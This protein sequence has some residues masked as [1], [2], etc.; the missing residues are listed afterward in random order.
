M[1]VQRHPACLRLS[2]ALLAAAGLLAAS[3]G[4]KSKAPAYLRIRDLRYSRQLSIEMIEPK[5]AVVTAE[6]VVEIRG[7]IRDSEAAVT[8]IVN[9]RDAEVDGPAKSTGEFSIHALTLQ[10]GPNEIVFTARKGTLSNEAR[11]LIT[12]AGAEKIAVH[13]PREKALVADR[14][15]RVE[16]EAPASFKNLQVND[17]AAKRPR[18]DSPSFTAEGVYINDGVNRLAVT[19]VDE[20]G[21]KW[22]AV[23][24]VLRDLTPPLI[25]LTT[26]PEEAS[27]NEPDVVFE[28]TLDD[29][30]AR[31]TLNGELVPVDPATGA[32]RVTAPLIGP[33]GRYKLEA[34]DNANNRSEVSRLVKFD[35]D[36]PFVKILE[37]AP[38]TLLARS[39]L[40]LKVHSSK[41]PAKIEVLLDD[42]S[43]GE[44][45][46]T[47][48]PFS[49]QVENLDVPD[50]P[51]K[52]LVRLTDSAGNKAEARGSVSSDTKAPLIEVQ[53]VAEGMTTERARISVS[54]KDPTLDS[55]SVRITLDGRPFING[56][57]L[58]YRADGGGARV[59]R[60]E[61]RDSYNHAASLSIR[62]HLGP[63][64][65]SD[66]VAETA[67]QWTADPVRRD[68]LVEPLLT[69][70]GLA[71]RDG[72]IR[73][74]YGRIA[75]AL[76]ARPPRLTNP[77][78][79][80]A[81]RAF[82]AL[83]P[84]PYAMPE[85]RMLYEAQRDLSRDGLYLDLAGVIAEGQRN[86]A[87]RVFD[88]LIGALS[89]PDAKGRSP[90]TDILLVLDAFAR[91][92]RRDKMFAA[93]YELPDLDLDWNPA[94][95]DDLFD[96]LLEFLSAL[97]EQDKKDLEGM[98]DFQAKICDKDAYKLGPRF[99]YEM[100]DLS[101]GNSV[102]NEAYEPLAC[103]FAQST[104]RP[105]DRFFKSLA[106][107]IEH[108]LQDPRRRPITRGALNLAKQALRDDVLDSAAIMA[109]YPDVTALHEAFM[110]LSQK[111]V[112]DKA[113][114]DLGRILAAKD[115]DGRPVAY[116]ILI[117]LDGFFEKDEIH[118]NQSYAETMLDGIERLLQRDAQGRNSL[119]IVLDAFL[120]KLNQAQRLRMG[121]IFKYHTLADGKKIPA[122][123]REFPSDS[124]R[125][126]KLLDT[127]YTPFSCGAPI[128]FTNVV[129][130]INLPGIPIKFPTKNL[131]VAAFEASAKLDVKTVERFAGAFDFLAKVAVVGDLVCEPDVLGELVA[132]PAPIRALLKT[133]PLAEIFVMIQELARRGDAPYL[134]ELLHSLYLSGAV[135]LF[136]PTMNAIFEQGVI[137]NFIR[138][139]KTVR[140]TPL[141][142]NPKR[143]A[144]AVFLDAAAYA[145][146]VAPGRRQR[147]VRPFLLLL[148]RVLSNDESRAQAQA[149]LEWLSAI[150]NDP[151]PNLD[152]RDLDNIAGEIVG[153]DRHGKA[154]RAFAKLM[155]EDPKNG[156][157]KY[158]MPYAQMYLDAPPELALA[159]VDVVAKILRRGVASQALYL[160]QKGVEVDKKY[161]RALLGVL[162][163]VLRPDRS[164]R[165]PLDPLLYHVLTT[166]E[167]V[168]KAERELI[169]RVLEEKNRS[170][171][172]R[173][174]RFPFTMM[175]KN[176]DVSYME[177]NVPA[178]RIFF[179][180]KAPGTG[181]FY[182]DDVNRAV[183]VVFKEGLFAA[184]ADAQ[185]LAWDK[186][187]FTPARQPDILEGYADVVG[188]AL[189]KW[190]RVNVAPAPAP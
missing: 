82:Q 159:F 168:V 60:V 148:D 109:N 45:Q 13:S 126:L 180:K 35:A 120:D 36:R 161:D 104:N 92:S 62:F 34:L 68:R 162:G 187:Y 21:Q 169:R 66:W 167:P 46:L 48:S 69:D 30:T 31:L 73:A 98:L 32:F 61:A 125:L 81:F 89:A 181:E 145:L 172:R 152:L 177:M 170:S 163:D 110:V 63:N 142:S 7:R 27:S 150:L 182:M 28:G 56:T 19:G 165:A 149:F 151:P 132:D 72:P 74:A 174:M 40:P 38:G 59:L 76:S 85:L 129:I 154:V 118:P 111:E 113:L 50:G 131:A 105:Y 5:G 94:T 18:P 119:E 95:K 26:P 67:R 33:E 24:S 121:E 138:S 37:P 155:D 8:A 77:D 93:L 1:R 43:V 189:K 184:F 188:T 17:I 78:V 116:S 178:A 99:L 57:S 83:Y 160:L 54:V 164:G 171:A 96:I 137:E 55:S 101:R 144:L 115:H 65:L 10:D 122:K 2:S 133:T 91:Y 14:W 3:C 130:P 15:I 53:G 158:L 29:S 70:L 23:V 153:C 173:L 112:F 79:A 11:V 44:T 49:Y 71:G 147:T 175:R 80:A 179:S 51:H 135:G 64:D 20:A 106:A 143:K 140:E 100:I 141:P 146:R 4:S 136:D 107:I 9:G 84:E 128:A 108:F 124:Q 123:G 6:R 139:L 183:S 87:A 103:V 127:C 190:K 22:L 58:D 185:R 47:A 114:T 86:G 42:V 52:L 166:A 97:F 25:S 41:V 157:I 39:F 75:E 176:G 156:D 90:L 88:K 186:G 16:G 134:V 117:A 12:R 102:V